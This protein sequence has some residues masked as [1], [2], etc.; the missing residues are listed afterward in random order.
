MVLLLLLPEDKDSYI[1]HVYTSNI[2]Y[3]TFKGRDTAQEL[4]KVKIYLVPVLRFSTPF[5]RIRFGKITRT[6][7]SFT[8]HPKRIYPVERGSSRNTAWQPSKRVWRHH[9]A[10]HDTECH[11]PAV[12][13]YTV[14]S[15]VLSSGVCCH[16]GSRCCCCRCCPVSG[17]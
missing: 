2:T 10:Y 13:L 3:K 6:N 15:W 11:Q 17:F 4:S 12:F 1:S 5:R 8:R 7:S 9:Q 16:A 14:R